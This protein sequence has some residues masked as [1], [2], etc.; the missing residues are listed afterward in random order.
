MDREDIKRCLKDTIS[1]MTLE[2]FSRLFVN[3]VTA[4]EDFFKLCNGVKAGNTISLLFNPHRL[5]IIT[6]AS[7]TRTSAPMSI[8]QSLSDKGNEL[9]T[10][11]IDG[12]A[13]LYLYNL[14]QGINNPFYCTIQR[15]YNGVAYVNEFP[16]FVARQ[17]Y[18][19]YTDRM[20][21][22]ILD[23]CAGW[24]GRMIGA[25]SLP[26]TRYVACEPCVET[27]NGLVKLG[28]WLKSLQPTFDFEIHNIP[29]EEFETDE[30]FDIALTS[31]PYFNTEHYSD[32][33]TD[34]AHKFPQYELWA[35]GFY[36]PL[37]V[38]T[39]N[40]LKDGKPFILNIGDRKY[41]LTN[42]MKDIC[43][44]N[45]FSYE[46]IRDYLSSNGEDGEKFFCIRNSSD[47]NENTHSFSTTKP[48]SLW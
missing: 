42:S 1:N 5:N 3:E 45:E 19:K 11:K 28:N 13:R 33:D 43:K 29:Y 39:V 18:Q 46:R 4:I 38:N 24:G 2:E 8:F 20:K 34:S 44:E 25:A 12:L 23:P 32:A 22:S 21:R 30:K 16:P 41:P 10:E 7:V 15:G 31:P 35:N 48:K 27:Y 17:I 47:G 6:E 37:I 9:Y 26:N 40:R 36:K 14:E